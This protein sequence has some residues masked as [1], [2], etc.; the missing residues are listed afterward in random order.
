MDLLELWFFSWIFQFML[1]IVRFVLCCKL[2]WWGRIILRVVKRSW[3]M[4]TLKYKWCNELSVTDQKCQDVTLPAFTHK[5]S[6]YLD[7]LNLEAS[8][9][10]CQQHSRFFLLGANTIMSFND[11]EA[12]LSSCIVF[13]TEIVGIGVDFFPLDGS[14]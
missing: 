14:F 2:R 6:Y 1:M 5:S 7:I 13:F 3:E 8:R 10:W 12:L 9:S 11:L 4:S